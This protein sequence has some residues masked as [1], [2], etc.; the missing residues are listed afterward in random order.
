MQSE[1]HES[2][3]RRLR[4]IT[5]RVKAA[6]CDGDTEVL[7]RLALEHKTVMDRLNQAGLSTNADLL[8]LVK[9]LSDEAREVFAE[10]GKQRDEIGRQLVTLGKRKKMAYAYA[11]N[12]QIGH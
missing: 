7:E 1:P 12:A 6:L 4:N 9:E 5:A 11:R 2:L 10:I 3:F 8:D